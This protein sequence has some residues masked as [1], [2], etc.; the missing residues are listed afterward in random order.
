MEAGDTGGRNGVRRCSG[1]RGEAEEEPAECLVPGES[2]NLGA[3]VQVLPSFAPHL[4]LIGDHAVICFGRALCPRAVGLRSFPIAVSDNHQRELCRFNLDAS[5]MSVAVAVIYNFEVHVVCVGMGLL[6][7]WT[8]DACFQGPY[9]VQREFT[10][11]GREYGTMLPRFM[12]NQTQN[13]LCQ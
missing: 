9:R 12:K 1:G 5:A 11:L 4:A 7:L 3:A 6:G 8:H 2:S 13:F 10:M